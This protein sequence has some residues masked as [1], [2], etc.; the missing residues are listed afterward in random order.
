MKVL[1]TG[2]TGQ[3]GYDV[4]KQAT[5]LD[6][7]VTGVGSSD[8]DITNADEV[9]KYV[10][11]LK[12]EVII[13]CAAYT[14][15]DLAEDKKEEAYNVNVNGT[16]NLCN[17][18]KEIDC[19]FLYISTDYVFEGSGEDPFQVQ[20]FTNPIGYY[21]E[22]KLKGEQVAQELLEKFFVVRIS[23]VFGL[24]GNNFVKTMIRLGGER[25]ELNIVSDQ[26]GS[27]T[28]T[29]DLAELIVSM[30]QTEKYGIY[31]ATNEGYCS[32]ADFAEAIFTEAELNVKVNRISS[33]EFPTK[34]RRPAN[35]RLD[36]SQLEI[37]GFKRLSKWNDALKRYI[38]ELK[39]EGEFNGKH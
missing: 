33:D 35:S 20:D 13:H 29:V 24:N 36:K 14:A 11:T 17:A 5:M 3:L 6:W 32:W 9:R 4:V 39:S 22:T 8:L 31:H 34:A 23:W 37:N 25:Q 2:S 10:E 38:K 1:I 16:L 28:Y 15:V 30:V 19:K 12:P 27:P 26:I 21:G 7:E 18:A